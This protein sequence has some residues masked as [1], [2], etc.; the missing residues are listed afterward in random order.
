M[1]DAPTYAGYGTDQIVNVKA[2]SGFPV[3]G[4]GMTDDSASLNAIL[5]Q[6]AANCKVT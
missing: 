1:Q 2:V 3:K 6:N 4:D 5:Q